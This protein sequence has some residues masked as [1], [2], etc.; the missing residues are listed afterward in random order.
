MFEQSSNV[1]S[2]NEVRTWLSEA[3]KFLRPERNKASEDVKIFP[4]RLETA[5]ILENFAV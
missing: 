4:Y 5:N 3:H 2:S 1:N